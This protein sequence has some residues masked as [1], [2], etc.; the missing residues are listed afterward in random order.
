MWYGSK[1]LCY[2][3]KFAIPVSSKQRPTW[4]VKI[5]E[6]VSDGK[7]IIFFS[8]GVFQTG[9]STTVSISIILN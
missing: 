3:R 7:N 8:F 4:S 2:R 9:P 6:K 5:F 1:G